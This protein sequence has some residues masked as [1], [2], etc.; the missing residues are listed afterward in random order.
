PIALA[1]SSTGEYTRSIFQVA[2]IALL[3]SWLAAV[4]VV[5]LLGYKLLPERA[6][7][8]SA[9]RQG[10]GT[11][12][13]THDVYGGPFYQRFRGWVAWCIDRRWGVIGATVVVFVAAL[14]AFAFVPQQF[15]PSSDR[16]EL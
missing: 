12:A 6:G 2:A 14:G 15:F 10:T 9:Q 5:P 4:T 11:H 3:L 7:D 13:G 8:P 1:R 16:P